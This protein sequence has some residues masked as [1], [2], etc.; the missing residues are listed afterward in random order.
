MAKKHLIL[1]QPNFG[2]L[3]QYNFD[4][5]TD[6]FDYDNSNGLPINNDKFQ[7]KDLYTNSFIF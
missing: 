1:N 4:D 7:N 5:T 6:D 3:S 2:D